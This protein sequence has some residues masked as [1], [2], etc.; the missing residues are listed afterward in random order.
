MSLQAT[1]TFPSHRS[2]VLKLGPDADP[3]TGRL[4]GR[5]EHIASGAQVDFDSGAELLAWLA[6][7]AAAEPAE[8]AQDMVPLTP[9]APVAGAMP[10]RA[11]GAASA[12]GERRRR[13]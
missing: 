2:Y 3:A 7:H 9:A 11:P 5:L 1:A 4:A 10:Q 12:S 8:A 6:G 13:R